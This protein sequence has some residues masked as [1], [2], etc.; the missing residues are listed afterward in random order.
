MILQCSA[1][2]I[3][4]NVT[5]DSRAREIMRLLWPIYPMCEA[6]GQLSVTHCILI[7]QLESIRWNVFLLHYSKASRYIVLMVSRI[8]VFLVGSKTI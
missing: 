2:P 5:S 8:N 1:V 6:E 7:G 3:L 4:H